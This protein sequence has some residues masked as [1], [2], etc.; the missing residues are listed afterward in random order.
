MSVLICG[1]IAYDTIMVF[2]GRFGDHILPDRVHS[3]SVGFLVPSLRRNYGGCGGNIAYNARLLGMDVCLLGA[4]GDDFAD[5]AA[6]LKRHGV[7][8]DHVKVFPGSY[9]AQAYITTDVDANQIT[10][11]HPGAMSHAHQ[12]AIPVDGSV[13]LAIV[14]PDDRAAMIGHAKSLK[15]AGI[16]FLFDPGQNLPMFN[17]EDLKGFIGQADWLVVNDYEAALVE[18]RTGLSPEAIAAQMRGYIVTRGA[19]GS[20]IYSQGVKHDIPSVPAQKIAD[21][22]GCGDAYRAGLLYGLTHGL[23]LPTTGRIA[24][25]LGSIK[26]E[27]HG[28]QNH[29]PD[30]AEIR[31]LYTAAF[32][33]TF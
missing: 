21:P 17:G 12:I 5:Y 25:L 1:S 29:S 4:A 19:Q 3:L 16:P 28:T 26:I 11:F 23:S 13:K 18:E 10:A 9:T 6:W 22:T 14:A 30:L 27:H 7:N 8:L 24:S 20:T 2:D 33:E 32:G 31:R 15:A